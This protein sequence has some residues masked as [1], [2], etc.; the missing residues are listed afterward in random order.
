MR[1]QRTARLGV[2]VVCL[3]LLASAA[4]VRASLVGYW[5]FE[6]GA[7]T[8]VHNQV[9]GGP[10]GTL[11]GGASF[12]PTGVGIN[13]N[14][15]LRLDHATNDL[16]SFGDNY[17][18]PTGPFSVVVWVK[19]N[20]GDTAPMYPIAKYVSGTSSGYF[21]GIGNV[22]GGYASARP[23]NPQFVESG[24]SSHDVGPPISNGT[25]HML[26][27]LYDP[28]ADAVDIEIDANNVG[29]SIGAPAMVTNT[30]ALLLGGIIDTGAATNFFTG[31]IDEVRIYDHRLSPTERDALYLS[32][33]PEPSMIVLVSLL[34]C[35]VRRRYQH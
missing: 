12:V 33:I 13:S 24:F 34:A 30:A 32:T 18:F 22:P 6:E 14:Y 7:G 8:V 23:G 11:L 21:I 29:G 1:Y 20:A 27:G 35:L 9:A 16:V 28:V 17:S 2:V 31:L 4:T 19:L 10:D 25:W 26:A 5:K 15:S 3:L